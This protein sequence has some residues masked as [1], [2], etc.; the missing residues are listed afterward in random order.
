MG[1]WGLGTLYEM[2]WDRVSGTLYTMGRAPRTGVQGTLYA[3]RHTIDTNITATISIPNFFNVW[4]LYI[5]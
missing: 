2:G 3:I 4:P 5:Q 1:D